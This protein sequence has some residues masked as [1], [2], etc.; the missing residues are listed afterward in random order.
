M[1][2]TAR[3][4]AAAAPAAARTERREKR[5]GSGVGPAEAEMQ[6][7]E[8]EGG[9]KARG[10]ARDSAPAKAIEEDGMTRKRGPENTIQ[11]SAADSGHSNMGM[12][13]TGNSAQQAELENVTLNLANEISLLTV[14]CAP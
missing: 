14:G 4:A 6:R 13:I 11:F 9:R 3:A 7:R 12:L 8:V 5:T 10:L 2:E 1:A